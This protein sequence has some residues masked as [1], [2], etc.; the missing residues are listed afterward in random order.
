MKKKKT[1]T[2]DKTQMIAKNDIRA[3]Q[4]YNLFVSESQQHGEKSFNTNSRQRRQR[5]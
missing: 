2:K 5:H 1:V 3:P 4:S